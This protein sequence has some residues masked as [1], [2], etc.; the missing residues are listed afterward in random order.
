MQHF[1]PTDYDDDDGDK[2]VAAA[3]KA[4]GMIP[5]D[6]LLASYRPPTYVQI[7]TMGRD[8]SPKQLNGR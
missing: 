4:H 2:K 8:D 1:R 3:A 7:M 5:A 6:E